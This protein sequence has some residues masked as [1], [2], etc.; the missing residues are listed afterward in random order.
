MSKSSLSGLKQKRP[1][2]KHKTNLRSETARQGGMTVQTFADGRAQAVYQNSQMQQMQAATQSVN[3]T[4]LPDKLKSGMENLTGLS[5]DHVRVHYNSPKPATVQ[6]HAYAQGSNIHLASGQEKHL[7]HELGHVV[8]QMQGRVEPTIS[9]GGM[10]VNDNATL[11]HEA[12]AMGSK[13]LQCASTEPYASNVTVNNAS[14]NAAQTPV[15]QAMWPL[16]GPSI[17]SKEFWGGANKTEQSAT[18]N[19]SDT[20]AKT[21]K[22]GDTSGKKDKLLAKLK[23]LGVQE[24]EITGLKNKGADLSVLPELITKIKG[25]GV[26]APVSVLMQLYV[27]GANTIQ[28]GLL[29]GYVEDNKALSSIAKNKNIS[30]VI[31]LYEKGASSTQVTGL[32][33]KEKN[34]EKL[35][36]LIDTIKS[37]GNDKIANLL[38]LYNKGANSKQI[39]LWLGKESD[40]SV[41]YQQLISITGSSQ[42]AELTQLY[43]GNATPEQIT[44]L[45]TKEKNAKTLHEQI[46][47]IK[48]KNV[49]KLI[50]LYRDGASG[51]QITDLF[52]KQ[53]DGDVLHNQILAIDGKNVGALVKLYNAGGK[54]ADITNLLIH[55]RDGALLT[56]L[57]QKS[58]NS[59]STFLK[60]INDIAGNSG[61]QLNQLYD[62]G[63]KA[64]DVTELLSKDNDGGR[65]HAQLTSIKDK[66][67]GHL[68][69][70]YNDGASSAQITTLLAKENG[71]QVLHD[72]INKIDGKNVAHLAQLYNDNLRSDQISDWLANQPKGDLIHNE[73]HRIGGHG[74]LLEERVYGGAALLAA[75]ELAGGHAKARHVEVNARGYVNLQAVGD[76]EATK[77]AFVDVAQQEKAV[78]D[79]LKSNEGKAALR[80]LDNDV[81]GIVRQKIVFPQNL[82]TVSVKKEAAGIKVT[83]KNTTN[84]TLIIEKKVRPGLLPIYGLHIVTCYPSN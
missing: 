18:T 36:E 26:K 45:L 1:V 9:V 38:N 82:N 63:A 57:L 79:A 40:G 66:N 35:F 52:K 14:L 3:N 84:V 71:G 39:E 4:G 55:V 7:P 15:M 70:L 28:I 29:L 31:G 10:A 37:S 83:P 67:V 69:R 46:T 48:D 12:T 20:S 81:L 5:L 47:R 16:T 51:K 41:L 50:Q 30:A 49:T 80:K 68:L 61:Q 11:E 25:K 78:E 42:A 13:A 73:V 59:V 65:L 2:D 43:K 44:E 75:S 56:S 64:K 72:L 62:D 54:T 60:Q 22:V 17:F 21:D 53:S 74:N 33:A 76:T 8:Q 6:A 24:H 23:D 34:E 58:G 19:V 77:S 32:L 27:N